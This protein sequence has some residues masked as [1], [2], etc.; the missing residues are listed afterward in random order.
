[1]DREQLRERLEQLRAE[2]QQ[3]AS[4]DDKDR[5]LL[6]R[7]DADIHEL[8]ESGED[9]HPR[10]YT[11]VGEGLREAVERFEASHPDLTMTMGQLAE[12]LARMGI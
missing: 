6:E 11:G 10:R 5:A 12:M 2:L 1:M 4:V 3:V 8:L 7:L 9:D